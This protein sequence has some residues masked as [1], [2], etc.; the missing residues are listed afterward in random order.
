MLK[1]LEREGIVDAFSDPHTLGYSQILMQELNLC[2]RFGTAY[3]KA[4]CLTVD[5]G[6]SDTDKGKSVDYDK[7]AEA[8]GNMRNDILA[9]NINQ[10]KAGFSVKDN[11]ILYGLV[12]INGVNEKEA[13]EIINKRPFVSFDD[14]IERCEV[15]N[16]AIISLIKCGAFDS[17]EA[18]RKALAMKYTKHTTQLL[19]SLTTVQA[20]SIVDNGLLP[21]ELQKYVEFNFIRKEVL[22][23]NNLFKMINKTNGYYYLSEEALNKVKLLGFNIEFTFNDDGR[24]IVEKTKLQNTFKKQTEPLNAFLKSEEALVTYN[25]MLLNKEWIKKFF[26][27]LLD[28]EMDS[29]R[30]YIGTEHGMDKYDLSYLPIKNFSE[31]DEGKKI[32]DFKY[33]LQLIAGTVISSDKDKHTLGI[34]TKDG[35]V[36][37]KMSKQAFA[38]YNQIDSVKEGKAKTILSDTWFKAGTH[39]IIQGFKQ[40]EIF[41]AK[42]Y[43]SSTYPIFIKVLGKNKEG[44]TIFNFEK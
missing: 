18:D 4:A 31:L 15:S 23:K 25:R 34:L 10:S 30:T 20:Q 8:V 29:I 1:Y 33:E 3:W 22:A 14:F 7:I 5:S 28:W 40:G 21:Q 35:V 39:L 6:I 42:G 9:P 32:D 13:Q 38:Q 44:K 27:D 43:K 16:K 17:I 24:M 37:I 2:H 12:G 36:K 41:M 19:K 11:K 26:G